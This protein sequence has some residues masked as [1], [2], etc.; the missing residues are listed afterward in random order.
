MAQSLEVEPLYVYGADD[1]HMLLE[2][3]VTAIPGKRVLTSGTF[4]RRHT[5][6]MHSACGKR[7]CSL[8]LSIVFFKEQPIVLK[9]DQ[10]NRTRGHFLLDFLP[11]IWVRQTEPVP[12][13]RL[14]LELMHLNVRTA[15][16]FMVG[17]SRPKPN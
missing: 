4:C 10:D 17:E 15:F 16:I 8:L 7:L 5:K 2:N 1:P 12:K 11:L 6:Q 13:P 9:K 14:E 3:E